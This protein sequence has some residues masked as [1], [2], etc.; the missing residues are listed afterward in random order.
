MTNTDKKKSNS[1]KVFWIYAILM[2]ASALLCLWFLKITPRSASTKRQGPFAN[3]VETL[4]RCSFEKNYLKPLDLAAV[5]QSLH[6]MIGAPGLSFQAP[7]HTVLAATNLNIVD[8][9]AICIQFPNDTGKNTT[10][11]I[12]PFAKR[13]LPPKPVTFTQ[14]D[15]FFYRLVFE[16]IQRTPWRIEK[17][18]PA[19]LSENLDFVVT[20]Y[21]NDFFLFINGDRNPS[22][23]A[24]SLFI[25]TNFKQL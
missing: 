13:H 17:L 11:L 20:N 10:Y 9:K 14:R 4:Y 18:D 2:T 21:A 1:W 7:S 12:V 15:A 19:I 8:R 3:I 5:N 16:E 6:D 22:T 23:L 25:Y 24:K